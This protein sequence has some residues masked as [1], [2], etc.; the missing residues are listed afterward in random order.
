MFLLGAAVFPAK[1]CSAGAQVTELYVN[2]L[3]GTPYLVSTH[4]SPASVLLE[5]KLDDNSHLIT[6]ESAL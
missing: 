2:R 6:E 5:V 4:A 1:D 3:S